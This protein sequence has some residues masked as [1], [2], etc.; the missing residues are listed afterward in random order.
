MSKDDR[1]EWCF[2]CGKL[3]PIGLKMEF[4]EEDGKYVA[5]FTPGLEHQSYDGIVHGGIVSTMLDEVMARYYYAK[6]MNVVT[7]RLEVRFRQPTPVGVQLKICGWVTR[8]RG[9]MIEMAAEVA[10]PDGI[11][12]AE[13]KATLMVVDK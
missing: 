5:A 2:A 7:A 3:N 9:K 4:C 11:V 12:T 13:G 10:L 8:E 6:G 1:N